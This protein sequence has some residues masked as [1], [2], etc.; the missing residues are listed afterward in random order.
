MGACASLSSEMR[1]FAHE[2][3]DVAGAGSLQ[4]KCSGPNQS[5]N[6]PTLRFADAV[7]DTH[8]LR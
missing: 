5:E 8:V 3:T 2:E 7:A 1:S 4:A 6:P